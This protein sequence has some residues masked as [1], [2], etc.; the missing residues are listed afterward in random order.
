MLLVLENCSTEAGSA[1]NY[2]AHCDWNNKTVNK[3]DFDL[4]NFLPEALLALA[5][6]R[7]LAALQH[8]KTFIMM[9]SGER[10]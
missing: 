3:C 6:I 8:D 10:V 1:E 5:A 9:C 4:T 7:F 2:G